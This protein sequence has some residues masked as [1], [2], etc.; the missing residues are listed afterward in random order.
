MN[1]EYSSNKLEK[2]LT[3]PRLLKKH[4]SKDFKRLSIRLSELRA[5]NN[6]S[7]IPEV[8]PPRRH[9]LHGEWTDCWG[10][11]YSKNYRIILRPIG[12]FDLEN[13]KSITEIEIID[14][15]DYH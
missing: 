13:I 14:L 15:L 1:I 7:D 8:P 4:Y 11:D 9:K 3:N 2:I 10:I 5:A 6:L 12:E